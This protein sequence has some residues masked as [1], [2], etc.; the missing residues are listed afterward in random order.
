[1]RILYYIN[2]FFAGI[3]GEDKADSSLFFVEEPIGPAAGL[4]SLLDEKFTVPVV[5]VCG[6]NYFN[7]NK[8]EVLRRI[9]DKAKEY[10][11][12]III[13]GPAFNS[14]R[15]GQ[16]CG[17]ICE[18]AAK[19]LQ[20]PGIT[21]MYEDNPMVESYRRQVYIL[22]TS[23]KA[24]GMKEA[25]FKIAKFIQKI[26]ANEP[27]GPAREEGYIPR[28]IRKLVYRQE[29]AA[30]RL[31][32]M[33]EAK[34]K[35]QPFITEL[36]IQK[37]DKVAPALPVASLK[38][39]T[40]ALVTTGG[41]VPRGNPDRI[42]SFGAEIWKTYEISGKQMLDS[43]EYETIHG[44]Y[45][46]NFINMNPNYVV[47]VGIMREMEAEG[48]IGRLHNRFYSTSGVGAAVNACQK[49]GQEIAALLRQEK[50]DGVILTST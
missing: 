3:G 28:G 18:A 30:K 39:A 38:E 45:N 40:I 42:R 4:C 47:P 31:V 10:R 17:A 1:M 50:V 35:G 13:A 14:G 19:E 49:D 43:S 12:D 29:E 36:P 15:Y 33:L 6:D 2:Q 37:I 34:L 48:L 22:P 11:V 46:P 25:L 5:A 20:I 21:G 16:A 9:V 23:A 32:D 24:T 44:G 7:S 8:D 26:A 27:L 41:L